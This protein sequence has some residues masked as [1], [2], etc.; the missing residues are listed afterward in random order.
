[1]DTI[2][3]LYIV[4]IVTTEY[5]GESFYRGRIYRFDP[6]KIETSPDSK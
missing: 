2:D 3:I 5:K 1:V 6:D 4:H